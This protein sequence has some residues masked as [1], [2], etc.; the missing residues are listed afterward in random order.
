MWDFTAICFLRT[1]KH[2]L[3]GAW[4]SPCSCFFT[5]GEPF[6]HTPSYEYWKGSHQ[7][8]HGNCF[9]K[10]SRNISQFI[11]FWSEFIISLN[12]SKLYYI[13]FLYANLGP[14]FAYTKNTETLTLIHLCQQITHN[15]IRLDLK[16]FCFLICW[17][18][19]F[20]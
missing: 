4:P 7:F 5:L 17:P 3:K 11:I 18:I 12:V 6:V 10:Q 8:T 15:C 2:K 1:N 19:T 9:N 14:C 13:Y 20:K 16:H